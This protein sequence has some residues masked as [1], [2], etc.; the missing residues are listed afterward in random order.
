VMDIALEYP[1][2]ILLLA[3]GSNAAIVT[4]LYQQKKNRE[5]NVMIFMSAFMPTY[6]DNQKFAEQM[7]KSELPILDVLLTLDHPLALEN[8]KYRKVMASKEMKIFYRQRQY[9]S[10]VSGYYPKEQL[11][12]DI[13]GWLKT[14]GW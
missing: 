1:G 2:I 9:N 11:V 14:I 12:K 3:E 13:S 8:A 4:D 7:A 6:D 5:P 10:Y